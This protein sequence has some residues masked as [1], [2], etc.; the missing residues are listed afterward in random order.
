M[1][2][3]AARTVLLC[4]LGEGNPQILRR[5]I[6]KVTNEKPAR[7][8]RRKRRPSLRAMTLKQNEHGCA[9]ECAEASCCGV[10]HG[11]GARSEV[12]A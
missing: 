9:G 5:N 2:R 10:E 1:M 11:V 6:E 12:G 8:S 3:N 4:P 7:R